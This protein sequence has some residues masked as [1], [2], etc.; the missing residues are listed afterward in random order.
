MDPYVNIWDVEAATLVAQIK[1][2]GWGQILRFWPTDDILLFGDGLAD[3]AFLDV[4]QVP[5]RWSLESPSGYELPGAQVPRRLSFESPSGYELPGELRQLGFSIDA[6]KEVSAT[7]TQDGRELMAES[8]DGLMKVF[9]VAC[10]EKEPNHEWRFFRGGERVELQGSTQGMDLWAFSP[11][12]RTLAAV[13][14][15]TSDSSRYSELVLWDPVSREQRYRRR[16]SVNAF[17]KRRDEGS[18][19]RDAWFFRFSN[20][21]Q[22]LGLAVESQLFLWQTRRIDAPWEQLRSLGVQRAVGD[23]R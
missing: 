21:S 14:L 2:A 10:P 22:S 15:H 23:R 18:E 12:G 5:R 9:R 4:A 16:I 17:D 11:D 20:D 1:P 19:N 8:R 13:G 6:G 3:V 7:D